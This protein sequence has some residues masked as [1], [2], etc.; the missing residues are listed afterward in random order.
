MDYKP[1]H[2]PPRD[3]I[4]GQVI[5]CGKC[6]RTITKTCGLSGKKKGV[7]KHSDQHRFQSRIYDPR[8]RRV[9]P[10]R[11]YPKD[12]RDYFEFSKLHLLELKKHKGGVVKP[13]TIGNPTL[14]SDGLKMFVDWLYDI[15]PK[16][17]SEKDKLPSHKQKNLNPKYIKGI[18]A[19]LRTFKESQPDYVLLEVEE[20]SDYHVGIFHEYLLE[21]KGYAPKT[22]NNKVS[23][24]HYAFHFFMDQGYA[25]NKN[26]FAVDEVIRKN[27]EA[28]KDFIQLKDFYELI[29]S[30]NPNSGIVF[31]KTKDGVNRK[32]QYRDWLTDYW[33]LSLLT[34][35]RKE[36][37]SMLRW[38]DVKEKHVEVVDHKNS[39]KSRVVHWIPR[40]KEL[41]E[42]L[43]K[44]KEKYNPSEDG[45]LIEPED[46]RRTTIANQA[47]KSFTVF[48]RKLGKDYWARM[49]SLRKVH[50]TLML[51]RHGESYAGV[52]GMH[53]SIKTTQDNYANYEKIIGD[54][55]GKSMFG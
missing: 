15:D 21:D 23:S 44:L 34:G 10:V 43:V 14:L 18:I 33:M 32:N 31:E 5:W 40:T 4:K 48:W 6:N 49:Y 45:F 3:K 28:K 19:N 53:Q 20:I 12:M 16:G 13:L 22:Y 46:D 7:C 11:T 27:W 9:V 26:P 29:E 50:G 47:S 30:V 35:G 2:I 17:K 42:L 41:N 8:K 55:A 25:I 54:F 1:L 37:V 39:K 51:Q 38:S 24:M 36:D 52:F